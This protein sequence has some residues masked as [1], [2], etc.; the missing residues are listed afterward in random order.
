MTEPRPPL[1]YPYQLRVEVWQIAGRRYA[2]IH[3][4]EACTGPC[5]FHNPGPHHMAGWQMTCR[6]DR[7]S[8]MERVCAHGVG[9]PD[10]DSVAWLTSRDSMPAANYTV[11]GCDGCC[12]VQ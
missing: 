12:E 8:L 5:P 10:P 11:H 2:T 3:P 9:H 4:R 6:R 1:R 7:D